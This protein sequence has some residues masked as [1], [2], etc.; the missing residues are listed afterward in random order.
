MADIVHP[1]LPK[2]TVFPGLPKVL[3]AKRPPMEWSLFDLH[4]RR[5]YLTPAERR[6]FIRAATA[7]GD[8]V[9]TFCLVLALTGARI[10]E[11]LA[12]TINRVDER[13]GCLIFETLKR[14]RR[15]VFRAVPVPPELIERVSNLL[16]QGSGTNAHGSETRI[17]TFSRTTAWKRVKQVMLAV[18]VH[19]SVAKPRALR[20]AFG[21]GAVQRRIALS[22]IKRWL[23][24][25][26][27]ETTAIYADPVGDE[28]RELARLMWEEVAA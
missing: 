25:T 22:V 8:A 27:I 6:D 26:K 23:G 2:S 9:G 24:H 20:H 15:G 16:V 19:P 12:L 17:W 18:G 7:R 10:S 1:E 21:V 11:V 4:G 3:G 13:D 5:K 28:E 14:R